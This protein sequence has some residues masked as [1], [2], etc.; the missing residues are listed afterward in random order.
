MASVF[1]RSYWVTKRRHGPGFFCPFDPRPGWDK[2]RFRLVR[3]AR[4]RQY[5]LYDDGR[6]YDIPADRLEQHAI[7]SKHDT[8]KTRAV[9][10][11]LAAVLQSM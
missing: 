6:L 1:I 11:T 10:E 3:F 2:D 7:L 5:K 4:D 9:R 8:A